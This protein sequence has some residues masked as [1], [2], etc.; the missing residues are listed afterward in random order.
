MKILIVDDEADTR[1]KL[2]SHLLNLGHTVVEA[3]DGRTA[4]DK[5]MPNDDLDLSIHAVVTD[6]RMSPGESGLTLLQYLNE[7]RSK[8]P[9]L[10]HSSEDTF[11]VKGHPLVLTEVEEFFD[12]VRFRLKTEDFSEVD[13]FLTTITK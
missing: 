2:T 4:I 9:C 13:E 5:L 7:A 10:L 8:I 6:C 1:K 12:F 3:I 11:T